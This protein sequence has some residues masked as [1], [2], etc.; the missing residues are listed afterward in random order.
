MKN[1]LRVIACL[2]LVGA[3][4]STFAQT[5]EEEGARS[6]KILDEIRDVDLLNKILPII[7]TKAQINAVLPSIEKVRTK[8]IQTHHEEYKVL[9]EL[10]AQV[11]AAVDKAINDGEPP[12]KKLMNELEARLE[13][14]QVA[15]LAIGRNNENLVYDAMMPVLNSGQKKAMANALDPHLMNPELITEK[16]SD[17]DKIRFFIRN[18][19]LDPLAYD[20]MVKLSKSSAIPD[21]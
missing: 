18:I 20:I 11:A 9:V 6:T 7:W 15:R 8:V 17:E 21:K 1:Q 14:M 19:L 2:L 4:A 3:F 5:R 13:Q 16:M 10:D 12:G